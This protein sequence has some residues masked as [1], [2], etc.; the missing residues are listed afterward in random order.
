MTTRNPIV[1]LTPLELTRLRPHAPI[2][3]INRFNPNERYN[4]ILINV[5]V[6]GALDDGALVTILQH[7]P[8]GVPATR[9]ILAAN[10]YEFWAPRP[11]Q[12]HMYHPLRTIGMALLAV[13]GLLIGVAIGELLSNP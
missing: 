9:A 7:H 1:E 10:H 4:G 13:T 12:A 5:D 11:T 2:L 8:I 3:A 6:N